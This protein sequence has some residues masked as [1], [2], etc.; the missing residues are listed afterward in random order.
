MRQFHTIDQLRDAARRR[1]PRFAFDFV[2][3]GAGRETA[4][5]ANIARLR[6][7]KL[8][9]RV[10]QGCDDRSMA[11]TL[12]GRTWAAPLGVAPMGLPAIAWA[13]ADQA[14]ARA[15]AVANVPFVASTPAS[16]AIEDIVAINPHAWFQL[17]VGR[18]ANIVDLLLD[19]VEAAGVKVLL[20][21]VDVP[22]AG[23]RVRDL[24]NRFGMAFKPG[25]GDVLQMLAHPRWT[26]ATA[27]SGGPRFAN[28]ER[29]GTG[30][31]GGTA[32]AN[33]TTGQPER[34][35]PLD[36]SYLADLR[37]RWKGIL[38]VKGVM[39]PDDAAKA[40][41]MGAD[42]VVVSNHGGRQI[43]TAPAS[44]EMLPLVREA[45]GDRGAVLFD[46]GVR[47]G[48]DIAKAL[49]LGADFV[50]AGRAFLYGLG[51][52]GPPGA[53]RALAILLDEFDRVLPQ[54]GCMSPADLKGAHVRI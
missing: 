25:P 49:A 5:D 32:F 12:F 22:V 6:A 21:T 45:V 52:M 40:V 37:R 33:L 18:D 23:R 24:N 9:P 3:G 54:L 14:M 53:D 29:Y 15:A 43:D 11:T 19:R 44:I 36:W 50:L 35:R 2:D 31:R 34:R 41:A 39:H 4:L 51:A 26:L 17:Y 47:A 16:A 46:S 28:M 13:G 10:L 8:I 30:Q 20:L 7:L 48:E 42:G 38:L 1:L 27:L